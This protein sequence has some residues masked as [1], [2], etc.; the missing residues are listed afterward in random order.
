MIFNSFTFLIFLFVVLILY[1]NSNSL[2]RLK[3]LFISSI[4]FY[5]FWRVEFVPL[6][7]FSVFINYYAAKKIHISNFQKKVWHHD[8]LIFWKKSEKIK[9]TKKVLEIH[10]KQ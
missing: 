7:L 10:K 2:L 8:F 3:I 9:I 1:W 4:I 6:L 5:G